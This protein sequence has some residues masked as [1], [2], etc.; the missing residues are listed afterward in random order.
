[1]NKMQCVGFINI[2]DA[3]IIYHKSKGNVACGVF[4]KARC[5]ATGCAPKRGKIFDKLFICQPA[6]LWEATH[7]L[8]DAG[9]H[10]SIFNFVLEVVCCDDFIE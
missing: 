7:S 8:V 3:E 2:F 4:P 9:E 1:M 10:A 5:V 6:C